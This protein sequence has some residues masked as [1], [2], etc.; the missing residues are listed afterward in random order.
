MVWNTP[1]DRLLEWFRQSKR[2]E[3]AVRRAES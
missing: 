2:I 3:K 1:V